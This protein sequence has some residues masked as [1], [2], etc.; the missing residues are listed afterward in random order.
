MEA[1]EC[2]ETEV[3]AARTG[4]RGEAQ[5]PAG[6]FTRI[7]ALVSPVYAPCGRARRMTRRPGVRREIFLGRNPNADI[8]GMGKP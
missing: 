6:Y 1:R 4:N 7:A 5:V 3:F 2:S 8:A